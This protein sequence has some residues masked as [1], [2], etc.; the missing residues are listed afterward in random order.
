MYAQ[1]SDIA[2]LYD[3]SALYVAERDGAVD[4]DA[5]ARA[6]ASASGEIDSFVG[7]RHTLP[8]P[9]IPALLR[10]L[11]VDIAL[12]RLANSR[13]LLTDE[14]RR[15]Y[16]DAIATLRRLSKGEQDLGLPP[17]PPAEG[18]EPGLPGPRPI[19]A[20]GPERLFSREKMRGL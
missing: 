18:E 2:E 17:E 14:H 4:P 9:R 5:V 11:A 3:E 7:V 10:Q 6:L 20:T 15:R 13:A 8:L 1:Q 16:E 12:Y 19:V